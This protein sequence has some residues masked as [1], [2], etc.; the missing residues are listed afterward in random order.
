V[1]EL[2]ALLQQNGVG[3]QECLEKSDLQRKVRALIQPPTPEPHEARKAS[4][5]ASTS[6]GS[7]AAAAPQ[8]SSEAPVDK[9]NLPGECV[10]TA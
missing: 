6:S 3:H 4:G 8:G 9:E 10:Q 2:K 1:K 5:A 7:E